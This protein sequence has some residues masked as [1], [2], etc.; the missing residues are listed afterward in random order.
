MVASADHRFLNERAGSPSILVKTG[1]EHPDKTTVVGIGPRVTLGGAA[2][3]GQRFSEGLPVRS[4]GRR[5]LRSYAMIV[6]ERGPDSKISSSLALPTRALDRAADMSGFGIGTHEPFCAAR[7]AANEWT[8]QDFVTRNRVDRTF[9]RADRPGRM[10]Q[11]ILS[12]LSCRGSYSND[13]RFANSDCRIC[14]SPGPSRQRDSYGL[15][16][17]VE[18]GARDAIRTHPWWPVA[19][20]SRSSETAR[21]I[22]QSASFLDQRLKSAADLRV[23]HRGTAGRAGAVRQS[24]PGRRL[25]AN[26]RYRTL[27]A[28]LVLVHEPSRG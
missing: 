22:Q 27:Y 7:P 23:G 1:R 17:C 6:R 15:R 16:D 21:R 25:H 5:L 2:S 13:P 8:D 11:R 12:G 18:E 20:T 26:G 24:R 10:G 14:K 28:V 9:D 3:L 19:R 4:Q